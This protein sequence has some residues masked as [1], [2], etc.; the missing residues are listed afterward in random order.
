MLQLECNGKLCMC[1]ASLSLMMSL[2]TPLYELHCIGPCLSEKRLA[3]S[4]RSSNVCCTKF[5]TLYIPAQIYKKFWK[6][7]WHML[8]NG[9]LASKTSYITDF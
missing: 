3:L 4:I 7:V 6:F 2:C 9:G 1:L 5:L 8:E